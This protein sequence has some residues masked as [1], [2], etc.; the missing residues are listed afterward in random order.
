KKDY[1]AIGG[2]DENFTG[3]GGEDFEFMIKLA[4]FHKNIK[5]TK[6][7]MLNRF[8]KAPLLSQGF[9]KYLALNSLPY[10]FEKKLVFHIYHSKNKFLKYFRQY[11]KNSRLLQEKIQIQEELQENSESLLA[12]Y[13][14]LCQKHGVD[15]DK[16]AVLFD[17]YKPRFLSLDGFL[18]FLRRL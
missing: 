2:F 17:S 10:F 9:R 12:L 7:L 1:I 8:Y 11:H 4:L 5:P 18:L 14:N 3:H 6:D 13:E 15:I 16:Y